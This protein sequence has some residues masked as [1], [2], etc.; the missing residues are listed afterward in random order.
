MNKG[1]LRFVINLVLKKPFNITY[2]EHKKI[3]K[4]LYITYKQIHLPP[5]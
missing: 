1:G 5:T 2:L 4:C 3:F